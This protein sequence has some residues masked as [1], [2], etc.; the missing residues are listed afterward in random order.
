MTPVFINGPLWISVSDVCPL[1]HSGYQPI[2]TRWALQKYLVFNIWYDI[3]HKFV[4]VLGAVENKDIE[5][6]Y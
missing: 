6:E 5:V 2:A 1:P 4:C 3:Y